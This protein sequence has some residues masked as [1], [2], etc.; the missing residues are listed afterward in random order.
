MIR[1]ALKATEEI[2]IPL[3]TRPVNFDVGDICCIVTVITH[4][5]STSSYLIV[6]YSQGWNDSSYVFEKQKLGLDLS[7]RLDS[8][9]V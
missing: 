6:G 4:N 5:I 1:N 9:K 8:G 3:W 7:L 2:V